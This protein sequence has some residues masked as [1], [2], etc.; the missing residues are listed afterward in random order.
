M[1]AV[2]G[3][4]GPAPAAAVKAVQASVKVSSQRLSARACS[5]PVP[6]CSN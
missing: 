3:E 1:S 6:M 4:A 5:Y 2:S